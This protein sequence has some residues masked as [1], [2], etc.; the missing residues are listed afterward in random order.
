MVGRL[1]GR[2][3]V[4]LAM[5]AALVG[6]LP[7]WSISAAAQIVPESSLWMPDSITTE[8]V[9]VFTDG[10][11][12]QGMPIVTDT[13]RIVVSEEGIAGRGLVIAK[14]G[15]TGCDVGVVDF[16]HFRSEASASD[17]WI[18]PVGE[19][20]EKLGIQSTVSVWHFD[21]DWCPA[22][23]ELP[24]VDAVPGEFAYWNYG[25]VTFDLFIDEASGSLDGY[26]YLGD[27]AVAAAGYLED[28]EAQAVPTETS[29][30]TTATSTSTS[31]EPASGP[32]LHEELERIVITRS[33]GTGC[34]NEG[35]DVHTFV[36]ATPTRDFSDRN[37]SDCPQVRLASP[38]DLIE[39]PAG[40]SVGIVAVGE[41][42]Q[43]EAFVR[44]PATVE[45]P[46]ER[47][48]LLGTVWE[49]LRG[50]G[51]FKYT[52]HSI[53]N[54]PH[55]TAGV[56]GTE[57][58]LDVTESTTEVLVLE[59]VVSVTGNSGQGERVVTAG[60][61]VLADGESISEVVEIGLDGIHSRYPWLA[62][63]QAR[64][65]DV[66]DGGDSTTPIV[67]GAIAGLLLLAIL[68]AIGVSR[69]RKRARRNAPPPPPPP[70]GVAAPPPPPS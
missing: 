45:L 10:G 1:T 24:D 51:L 20:S 16:D 55:V 70:P 68:V 43:R 4:R 14:S 69:R 29:T 8:Y 34:A 19:D 5:L 40:Y 53:A 48:D 25:E 47:S 58:V 49:L 7:T 23:G 2:P 9:G 6:V 56:V 39:V 63:A 64:L 15:A 35:A 37:L 33:P 22:E 60:E 42:T 57:F 21:E 38:G 27:H 46:C 41:G 61:S 54:T 66:S 3:S 18:R 31:T 30:S 52:D 59:G 17:L 13:I 44:G 62:G 26:L 50:S 28:F 11:D 12:Y 36:D 65:L 67:I 32:A